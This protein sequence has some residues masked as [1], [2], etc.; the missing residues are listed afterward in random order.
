MVEPWGFTVEEKERE[1]V[2]RMEVPGFAASELEI[3]LTGEVLTIRAEHKEKGK[4]EMPVERR[5]GK[6]ERTVTLPAG[7]VPEKIEARYLNGVLE[8]HVPRVPEALPR[9]IEVKT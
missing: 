7:I 8:V 6:L 2:V 9:R 1:V 5:H 3:L 4:E